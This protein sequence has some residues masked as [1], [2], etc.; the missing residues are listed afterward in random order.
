MT[1]PTVPPSDWVPV[2]WDEC[3][4]QME[5]F[6]WDRASAEFSCA[7]EF[8][9]PTTAVGLA[10]STLPVTGTAEGGAAMLGALL[11]VVGVLAARLARR[12]S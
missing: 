4:R 1:T 10:P 11:L 3:I 8:S 2:S 7:T 6:G 5:Y 12:P 9:P